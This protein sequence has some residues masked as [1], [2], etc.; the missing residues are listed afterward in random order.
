MMSEDN[1]FIFVGIEFDFEYTEQW[2]YLFIEKTLYIRVE[3][4]TG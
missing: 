1:T 3:K 4:F 2:T